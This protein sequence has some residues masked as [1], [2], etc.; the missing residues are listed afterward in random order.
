MKY[1]ITLA[2]TLLT[3]HLHAQTVQP[4]S[5][6]YSPTTVSAIS[7]EFAR[8]E[9][10]GVEAARPASSSSNDSLPADELPDAPGWSAA[11]AELSASAQP[12]SGEQQSA[13]AVAP[14]YANV[15]LPGQ[16]VQPLSPRDKVI[17]GLHDTLNPINL[18]SITVSAGW[19]HLIDSAPHYGRNATAF[20]KREGAAAIRGTVQN[21]SEDMLFSPLFRTDPR[22]YMMGRQHNIVER[23]LYA[24]SRILVGKTDSGRR[25]VNAALLLGYGVAAGLNNLYYPDRDMG[26]SATFR[27]YGTSLAGAAGG[28]V[29]NEF[30]DDALRIVHLRK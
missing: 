20:G 1:V 15:I 19:S 16:T 11:P 7:P 9:L 22:Y 5:A 25:T 24:A 14:L 23:G 29:I 8:L 12:F 4:Q 10:A 27:S 28:M 26:V 2:L 30:L 21:L 17:F 18:L 3:P 13:P 6:R